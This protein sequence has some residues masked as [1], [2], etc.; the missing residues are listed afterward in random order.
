MKKQLLVRS[1]LLMLVSFTGF[2][3][4]AQS[5]SCGPITLELYDSYG[6]GWNGND[7][8]VISNSGTTTTYTMT[9]GSYISY[10]LTVAYGDTLDFSWQA[11]GS[12]A[13]ECTY[14]ILDNSGNVLYSSPNG[15]VMTAGATQY[16]VYCNTLSTCAM[17][18][19]FSVTTGTT[20]AA[21]SWDGAS[22]YSYHLI[23]Y[24]TAGFTPGTGDTMWVYADTA[25][26]SNLM[27]SIAYD[28]YLTTIC[29]STDSSITVS[30]MNTY[31]QCAA[32][33]TPYTENF[34]NGPSGSYTNASMPNCWEYN[35]STTYP[36][37]YVRNYSTYANSGS[38]MVY[39][40]KSSGTPNGTTYGDTAFFASPV[41]QGLDSATKQVEF[42]ARTSSTSYLGMVLVGVTDANATTFN[43][44]DTVYSTTAY[45]KY[46]VYLD[47]AAGVGTGDQRVAFAWIWDGTLS[48]AYDYVYIDDV[49]IKDIPPCPEPIGIGLA[50]ATQ[51]AATLTWSSSASAF[52]IEVGPTGFTQGTGATYSSTTTSYT[53]TGLTQNTYY[54]AYVMA[55]C[56]ATGDGTSNWVG[57]F[58]FK[59]E[60]GDQAVPY[61]TGFE[62]GSGSTSDPDLGDCW[63]Y[64]KTGTSTSLYAYNYNYNY[65]ANTGNNSVRFYGYA[66]TTSTNS[67]D[68]DTLAAFSPRI[69][70]LSGNDKQVIFNVR[71]S[72]S[73]AYYTTKMIIATAD[74]NASLGSI[75]I[76]DTVNY[77]SVY[78]EFTID[79]DNVPTNASRVV[80]MIVPEFVSGYTYAYAYAYLD[81]I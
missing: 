11:G 17:P 8:D 35:S 19:N 67:A 3:A 10:S 38:Q 80:F 60:C 16:Y 47:A 59:T 54:D 79:L 4:L 7:M 31:T 69:A 18:T 5:E 6:D 1:L 24:D 40:Y 30:S 81:D 61:S 72:S 49:T 27:S 50:S 33:V 41:I 75:H 26:I 34:D 48:P 55:N 46:T 64:A 25:Y 68:G 13:S 37:W 20:D 45:A 42:Y 56:T 15:G 76:V 74:S 22:S 78:Q 71:T 70:G 39:G 21:L 43:V 28:F 77:S 53:A 9:S 57:P 65:Y 62:G 32:Y 44:V 36:Y 52:N 73:V 2:T 14:K 51:S 66:S 12:W 63:A 58:T 23:E 29:S